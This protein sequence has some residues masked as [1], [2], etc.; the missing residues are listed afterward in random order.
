MAQFD[1]EIAQ[2]A[3]TAQWAAS[4]ARKSLE[5]LEQMRGSGASYE[6]VIAEHSKM[7]REM[8]DLASI[9]AGLKMDR[10][11]G[12][13]GTPDLQ[14]IENI[15]G[16][17][18]PFEYLVDIPINPDDTPQRQGTITIS[19]EGPFV[20]TGR[21][22]TFLSEYQ[23]Q[24]IDPATKEVGTFLGRSNGRFRPISSAADIMDGLLPADV[25][26]V[27]AMPGTGAPSYASPSNH[28]PYR[29]M[30]GDYRIRVR[31]QDSGVPRS[32]IDVPST[33]WTTFIN[34]PF[35]L[36]ALDFFPRASVIELSVTPQHPMNPSYGNLQG[37]GGGAGLFPF[38]DSQYDHHE[39][40]MDPLDSTLVAG[41]P[42]P[43]TRLPTGRLVIGFTG[44]RIMQPPAAVANLASL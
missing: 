6:R 21:I 23:F 5:E 30:E 25:M 36:A 3:R 24:R 33:F 1:A 40:I 7:R 28:S 34:S 44:Y 13:N 32:N 19:M 18:V 42:D 35:P 31:K 29:T 11:G 8:T 37:Y 2:I 16:E 4:A 43:I 9:V 12:P 17:R 27:V 41:D 15:P 20:A 14:R 22:C 10:I 26:R 39:G 38:I